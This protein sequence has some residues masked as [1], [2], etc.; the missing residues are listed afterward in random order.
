MLQVKTNRERNAEKLLR[1]EAKWEKEHQIAE[2]LDRQKNEE[3]K[4]R[5]VQSLINNEKHFYQSKHENLQK[6]SR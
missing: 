1:Q 4:A 2:E 5:R 3:I 6:L